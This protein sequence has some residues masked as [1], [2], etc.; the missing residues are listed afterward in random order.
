MGESKV[1]TKTILEMK[2]RN[3]RGIS[4]KQGEALLKA[5]RFNFL[6][7][8]HLKSLCCDPKDDDL[9]LSKIKSKETS[10]EVCSNTDVQIV[11]QI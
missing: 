1:D 4:L 6:I 8:C 11:C 3:E 10:M 2:V 9:Y 5:S 7:G